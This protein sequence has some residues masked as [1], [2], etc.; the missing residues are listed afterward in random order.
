MDPYGV[1]TD[2]EI[3][4]VENMNDGEKVMSHLNKKVKA[5]KK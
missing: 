3:N 1:L 5:A 4:L 2:V